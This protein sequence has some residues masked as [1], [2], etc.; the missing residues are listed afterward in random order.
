LAPLLELHWNEKQV[1]GCIDRL[2]MKEGFDAVPMS[3]RSGL[4]Y[5]AARRLKRRLS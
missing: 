3:A 5:A 4:G 2:R 1:R